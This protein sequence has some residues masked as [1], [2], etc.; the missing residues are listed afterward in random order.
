MSLSERVLIVSPQKT[1]THLIQELMLELDFKI[2]GATRPSPRNTPVFGDEER[3]RIARLVHNDAAYE[4]IAGL[5]GSPEFVTRTDEAW[6]ALCWSWYRRFGQPVANRYGQEKYD[7]VD[8]TATNPTLASTR[9]SQTPP[10]LCWIWHDLDISAVDGSFIGEWCDTGEP[11]VVLNYRDPRDA[12]VSLI[13]FVD[14]KTSK[15]FGNFYE[16]RVFHAILSSKSTMS[17]KIDYA[18]RDPYFL[19]RTEYEKA[20]W[21]LHHPGV[22]KVRYED[23]VGPKGGG[24]RDAQ[25]TAVQRVLEHV[26]AADQDAEAIADRIYNTDAWSFYQGRTGTWREV[27]SKENVALFDERYGHVLEQYGYE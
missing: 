7:L 5:A 17:E 16:R 14:G 27:F 19:A 25:V 21:L 9:F 3:R 20:I 15:G 8:V 6:Q 23:L 11:P 12:L 13:N 2:V 24:S 10:G 18:L 26:N 4:E 1:G 22:C